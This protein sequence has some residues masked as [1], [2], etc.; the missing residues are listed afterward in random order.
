MGEKIILTV[1]E[2]TVLGKKVK[3]L[4]KEGFVPAI[5]Y[6]GEMEST[7]V[8]APAVVAEKAWRD[9][10]KH[11]VIE[12]TLGGK[13]RLA[14][15]KSADIEPVKRRLRHL[16][17]HVVKQNEKVETEV[18]VRVRGEGET[19]A[20]KAGFVV[21]KT[22]ES[23]EVAAL[24][25]SL[26]DFMEV[27][28]D[29]LTEPGHHL[30]VADII[31]RDGVEVLSEPEQIVVTVYE[32]GALAAANDAAGGDATEETVVTAEN[33]TEETANEVT[34]QPDKSK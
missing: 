32:P 1:E 10:G 9:A 11:H 8:M 27:P 12:L 34:N 20:E 24:P 21:L 31:P 33:G 22:I 4:R 3:Q 13:T 26:P 6:G 5:V 25:N 14:M 23:V 16:S 17:L 30:T 28:G 29:K 15:I 2:R 18:P 7:A 19:P